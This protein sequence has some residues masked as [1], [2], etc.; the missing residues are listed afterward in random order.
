MTK[1]VALV[2]GGSK[3]IGAA[4]AIELANAKY[5]V[6]ITG[7]NEDTLKTTAGQHE[8][9]GY[10]VADVT[11]PEA[12]NATMEHIRTEF[13]R[14]DVLVNNAGVAAPV[15]FENITPEHFDSTFNINVRGLVFMTQKALP[16]L[17]KSKGNIINI[18]SVA[19]DQPFSNFLIYSA[20]KGAV[21]TISKGLAKELA[22][23]GIRVNAIS[24]GPIETSIFDKMGFD[25]GQR[26]R[27]EE[28]IGKMVPLARIGTAEEVAKTVAFLASDQASYITGAQYKIDGGFS[29]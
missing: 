19:G 21:I 8:S 25:E 14:L 23:Y 11:D 9:I 1:K 18:S 29:A 4:I 24:P 16:L 13:G 27:L 26:D 6:L 3:G 20:T 7:R 5:N 2:T 10:L 17:K 12:I 28:A 22:P 15:P